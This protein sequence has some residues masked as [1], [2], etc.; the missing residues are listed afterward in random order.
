MGHHIQYMMPLHDALA[1]LHGDLVAFLEGQPDVD[2]Q[3]SVDHAPPHFSGTK[4]VC[5]LNA[6]DDQQGALDRGA[7]VLVNAPVQHLAQG[8]P[9]EAPAHSGH[10]EAH[11]GRGDP[12]KYRLPQQVADDANTHHQRRHRVRAHM[13]SIDH[14]QAELHALA[15]PP[16]Q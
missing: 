6:S 13:P 4:I 14:Q 1:R 9:A 8:A 3:M 15:P 2:F 10:H 7:V 12:A 5:A 11:D 16:P